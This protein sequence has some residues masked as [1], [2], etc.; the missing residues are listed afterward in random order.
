MGV[1]E[2]VSTKTVYRIYVST[3]LMSHCAHIFTLF[4]SVSKAW[5]S[6]GEKFQTENA[7]AEGDCTHGKNVR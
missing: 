7:T 6:S 5:T 2:N 3:F 1:L 4:S